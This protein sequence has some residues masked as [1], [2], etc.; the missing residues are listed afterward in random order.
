MQQP[1]EGGQTRSPTLYA[2]HFKVFNW[3]CAHFHR[4]KKGKAVRRMETRQPTAHYHRT[5][6]E[7]KKSSPLYVVIHLTA[8]RYNYLGQYVQRTAAFVQELQ[9]SV[10]WSFWLVQN[11]V[12]N[13]NTKINLIQN[14]N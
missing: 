10:L 13:T 11:M 6:A 12:W 2:Q 9:A 14:I 7:P 8:A 5:C 4:G 3:L 1:G